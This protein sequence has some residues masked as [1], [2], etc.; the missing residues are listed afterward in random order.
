MAIKS[1]PHELDLT[2]DMKDLVE[3]H[4]KNSLTLEEQK[5]FDL[6]M[7]VPQ[8]KTF[9]KRRIEDMPEKIGNPVD[10]KPQRPW[11][12]WIMIGVGL[13]S[14]VYAMATCGSA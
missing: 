11:V 4:L 8:F 12:I 14:L 10:E 1:N 5:E 7:K 13:A 3:K 9:V 2:D 6:L